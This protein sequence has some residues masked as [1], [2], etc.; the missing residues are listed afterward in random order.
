MAAIFGKTGA[1]RVATGS[2]VSL[3]TPPACSAACMRTWRSLRTLL[4]DIAL[5]RFEPCEL[6]YL[7]SV[8][9]YSRRRSTWPTSRPGADVDESLAGR[10]Y[11][12]MRNGSVRD[13]G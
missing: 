13:L 3:A 2:G 1:A 10:L 8:P 7:N 9:G 12:E 11:D 5:R 6:C 4:S